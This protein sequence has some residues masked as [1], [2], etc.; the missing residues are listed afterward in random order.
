MKAMRITSVAGTTSLGE[1]FKNQKA[2][3][4]SIGGGAFGWRALA[5][6][7][8]GKIPLGGG[9]IPKS[10]IA[11]AGTYVTGKS[12]ELFHGAGTGYTVEQRRDVYR[13]ALERGKSI[14]QSLIP[15]YTKRPR[16]A[17]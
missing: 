17:S 8:V 15:A 14:A 1:S 3:I 9:L 4:L 6:E 2:E 5:R 12:L 10:A 16:V 13:Q 11:Y 7:L